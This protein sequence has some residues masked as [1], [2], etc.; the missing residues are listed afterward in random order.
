MKN[1]S[2]YIFFVGKGGT[3]KSTVSALTALKLS[4][5]RKILL[6]SLDPAHNQS[7]I[8]Q[9]ALSEKPTEINKNLLVIEINIGK[10]I[11]NYLQEIEDSVRRN[12]LY[13]SAFNLEKNFNIIK[14]S[15]GLEEYALLLAFN[16][17][18][19]IYS[20]KDHIIFDMP[21]TALTTRFFS[22]PSLSLLWNDH[23]VK[24]RE[25]IIKKKELI[26]KIR[27][28]KKEFESD[29]VLKKLQQQHGFYTNVKNIF[30]DN[31][32]TSINLVLNPDKLSVEESK[33][34]IEKFKEINIKADNIIINKSVDESLS[35]VVKQKFR[36][37]KSK[38]FPLSKTP[39]IGR[40]ALNS[41]LLNNNLKKNYFETKNKGYF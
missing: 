36:G 14:N 37:I 33:R 29:K 28:N 31:N 22:L 8:F 10:W 24:L 34:I 23:L 20:T 2:Q 12:Y 19:E 3:G 16:K 13:L 32:T 26:T 15:P 4:Q 38:T 40:E 21:P 17:I 35:V 6:A 27:F 1:N 11:K 39:L 30:T 41:Y 9:T 5:E 25:E 7:D 18:R